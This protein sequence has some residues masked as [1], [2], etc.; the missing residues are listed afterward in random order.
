M[1]REILKS[2]WVKFLILLLAVSMTALSG[3]FMLRELMIR[4]FRDY[5][6]GEME[7]RVYWV[8][9]DIEGTYEKYSG[10]NEDSSAED[11]IWALMLGLEITIKDMNDNVIMDTGKAINK[12]PPLMQR[13]IKAISEQ[14]ASE[15]KGDFLPYPLFLGGKEI[16]HLEVKFLRPG[17]ESIFIQ[18][19]NKFL[20]ISLFAIGGL[21]ILLSIIFSKR[22][23]NPL[24]RLDAAA[25]AISEG[26]L[27]SRVQPSGSDEINRLSETFNRMAQHLEQ[28]ESL[29]KRLI[30]NVAHE[31]RTPLSAVRGEL[32]GMVDGIIPTDKEHLQSLYEEINRLKHIL[33][34]IEELSRAEAG[35]L[36][37]KKQ[38]V[39]LK[40]FLRNITERFIKQAMERGSALELQCDDE[41]MVL[42]DPDRLS[43]IVINLLS[44]AIKATEE[45]GNIWVRAGKKHSEVFIE[46]SD[47]GCGI[48]EEDL[49][50]IFERF[51]KVSKGGLGLGL[52]VAKE[53]T[54]AHGGRIEVKSEYGKGSTFTVFIPI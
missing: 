21:A 45:G 52:A 11:A 44:N 3:A 49:P 20:L 41:L 34:G 47:S 16:G 27:K 53:L 30:S 33:E 9:A 17:K 18:R 7:D 28:Q 48:R 12:L 29:R 6:E 36:W 31:L 42:A 8:I 37:L 15:E 43:Q 22:L 24:K 5:L 13:R 25:K 40:S 14:R 26:N 39:N 23:T 51:Y 19:S 4:D 54:D 2:L 46:I 50:F 32:E 38:P 35:A 1:A 10:W